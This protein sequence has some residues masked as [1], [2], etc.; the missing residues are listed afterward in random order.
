[1]TDEPTGVEP[2]WVPSERRSSDTR[3]SKFQAF[4]DKRGHGPFESYEAM[5]WFSVERTRRTSGT[6]IWD[7]TESQLAPKAT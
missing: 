7:F 3:L 5:H 2:L 6:R 1:M 4:L